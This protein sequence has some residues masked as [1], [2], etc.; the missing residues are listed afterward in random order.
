MTLL[1]HAVAVAALIALIVTMTATL[2]GHAARIPL[3][4]WL[5]LPA[6][7]CPNCGRKNPGKHH[8]C[9]DSVARRVP[10]WARTE[11]R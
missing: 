3:G 6:R 10:S 8:D 9:S 7:R 11:T 5:P 1:T 2:T 4:N